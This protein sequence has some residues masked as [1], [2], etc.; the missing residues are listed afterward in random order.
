M[1]KT[2]EQIQNQKDY[3]LGYEDGERTMLGNAKGSINKEEAKE[4]VVSGWM[5]LLED[6]LMVN[7]EGFSEE[8][9]VATYTLAR[10]GASRVVEGLGKET[11]DKI[12]KAYK[13][14]YHSFVQAVQDY[15]LDG[16]GSGLSN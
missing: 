12:K 1:N 13:S 6:E 8:D 3:N 4:N 5:R 16:L 2:Q 15:I 14:G 11:P 10:D 9:V 7:V